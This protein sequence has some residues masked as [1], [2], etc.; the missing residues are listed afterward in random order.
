MPQVLSIEPNKLY[1]K[2]LMHL[3]TSPH[4]F[5]SW[6]EK[7]FL[8]VHELLKCNQICKVPLIKSLNPFL[9]KSTIN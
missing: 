3:S 6:G 8:W 7:F 5:V 9:G 4:V 1:N 2:I